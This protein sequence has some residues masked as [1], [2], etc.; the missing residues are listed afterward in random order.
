MRPD[1]QLGAATGDSISGAGIGLRA[2][3]AYEIIDSRPDVPWFEV[4]IDNHMADGGFPL[5]SLERVREDYPITLH[6]VGLSIGSTDPLDFAYLEKLRT[7]IQ[8][9]EPAWVSEHLCWTSAHGH[10]F[11]DLL[12]LPYTEETIAHVAR[13]IEAVQ[14]FLGGQILVE[15]VSSYLTF[16]DSEM[17]EAEFL[18]AVSVRADCLILLDINNV[19]VSSE[20]L[21]YDPLGYVSSLPSGRIREAHLG[22][23]EVRDG[24]LL[25]AHGSAVA[26]PVWDL[27]EQVTSLIGPIPTLVEWDNDLP[28]FSVLRDQARRAS[29]ILSRPDAEP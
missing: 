26:D 25:D 2:A 21:G 3:H 24:L 4:L 11:H 6:C 22:G 12:P 17:S 16:A 15:N 1:A 23:H 29:D 10:Y 19:F 13:R 14:E 20:N 5:R 9:F 8:R 27:F 18:S 28:P 7:F